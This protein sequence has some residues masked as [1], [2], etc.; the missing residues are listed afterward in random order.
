[1]A[2]EP[3]WEPMTPEQHRQLRHHPVIVDR[4]TALAH[5]LCNAANAMDPTPKNQ[6]KEQTANFA[7]VVQNE[8]GTQRPRAYVHPVGRT[9]L[10]VEAGHSVLLKA[11]GSIGAS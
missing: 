4:I 9:G 11:L 6:G 8:P 10:H 3:N 7:V 5:Q 2:D 1:M